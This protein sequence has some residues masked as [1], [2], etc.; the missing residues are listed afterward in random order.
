MRNE[1]SRN[2]QT[3]A[4][5]RL[6]RKVQAF[7]RMCMRRKKY[8]SFRQSVIL[9][10]NMLRR[11]LLRNIYL[12]MRKAIIKIETRVR[13]WIICRLEKNNRNIMARLLRGD[14]VLLWEREY[15]PLAYRSKFYLMINGDSYLHLALYEEEKKR[16]I[17]SLGGK[18]VR[19]PLVTGRKKN[20]NVRT[21]IGQ[22]GT[23]T[24]GNK[25]FCWS[26]KQKGDGSPSRNPLIS[27][28]KANTV[29]GNKSD[30]NNSQH[31]NANL[32]LDSMERVTI[33]GIP[34]KLSLQ[35][36]TRLLIS[37]NMLKEER[38]E[39]YLKLKSTTADSIKD[40]LFNMFEFEKKMR[41]RKQTLSAL[42]WTMRSDS[43]LMNSAEACLT[44][45]AFSSSQSKGVGIVFNG[46]SGGKN[47][48]QSVYL[49]LFYFYF[50]IVV[51]IFAF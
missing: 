23:G 11:K 21:P 33:I 15:T 6:I 28:S 24:V 29:G 8:N 9:I 19:S 18:Y 32:R 34:S 39:I 22:I 44:L 4:Y 26:N 5:L 3:K 45:S 7:C 2:R 38:K 31:N 40:S 13:S 10:Q 42:V 20:G 46:V 50:Y 27:N 30:K 16:L 41:K 17:D 48:Y 14:I 51:N 12:T 49:F 37:L 36:E 47:F 43:H 35:I 25:S 1:A